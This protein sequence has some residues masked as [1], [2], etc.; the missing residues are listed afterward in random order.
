M[1]KTRLRSDS[2]TNTF[3][4]ICKKVSKFGSLE[5][6][7]VTASTLVSQGAFNSLISRFDVKKLLGTPRRQ[8]EWHSKMKTKDLLELLWPKAAN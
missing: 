8:I 4:L 3:L 2:R 6:E 7:K 5:I 1:K